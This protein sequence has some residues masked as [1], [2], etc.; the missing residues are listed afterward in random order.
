M[1]QKRSHPINIFEKISRFL[2]LLLLPLLRALFTL[3][4][5]GGGLYPW[6]EG[7]WFDILIVLLI[8]GLGVYNW[9][10]YVFS[11]D[12]DGI[13]VSKGIFIRQQRYLPY[14]TISAVSMEYPWYFFPIRAVRLNAD[15]DGGGKKHADFAITVKKEIAQDLL[16][17]SKTAYLFTGQLQRCYIPKNLYIAIFS[18]ISSNTLTGVLYVAASISQAG[19]IFGKEVESYI[20]ESFTKVANVL[21]FGLPPAAAIVA[22]SI[23]I[24]WLVSFSINLVK[25]LR[26]EVSRC[27][28]IL[29]VKTGLVTRRRF[30]IRV[31]RINY[32]MI[33]QSLLSKVFGFFSVFIQCTGYGKKQNE[34]SV[35]MPSGESR[36]IKANLRMLLPE[37]ATAKK[38]IKPKLK[39]LSRFLIPP[40]GLTLGILAVGILGIYFFPWLKTVLVFFIIILEIPSVWWLVVK[41]FAFFYTGIG[42]N[43]KSVTLYYTRGYRII[44]SVIPKHKL[45]KM[46]TSQTL[47]QLS[48][49]CCDVV[50]YTFGEGIQKQKVLNMNLPE[51][52]ALLDLT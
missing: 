28:G 2:I 24:C 45:T 23:L 5:S 15:T 6:L 37:I 11:Y 29:D 52:K 32:L 13:Y 43:D 1:R 9:Y 48:T 26:F 17:A 3:L 31:G 36:D 21:A 33:R 50:F 10:V 38:Q 8:I 27:G 7:A 51:V 35:L 41:T 42:V 18:F 49:K 46:V 20:Y 39:N 19:N 22:Y 12:E 34:L 25:H 44:T 30:S 14:R 16:K 47:F 40:I 4:L